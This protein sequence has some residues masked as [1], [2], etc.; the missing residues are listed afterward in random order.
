MHRDSSPPGS[1]LSPDGRQVA[2]LKDE[3][4][5]KA[6]RRRAHVYRI[7]TDG[8]GLVQLT[9]SDGT[10][11]SPRWSPDGKTIAFVAKRGDT[12][13][14]QIYLLPNDGGEARQLSTHA[15]P[16]STIS[17]APDGTAIY[18][19][20]AEDKTAEEKQRDKVKDDVF[21]FDENFK[22]QHLW[23]VTVKDG[24]E[25]RL[26]TGNFDVS[27]YDVSADGAKIV[28]LRAASPLLDDQELCEVWIMEADGTGAMQV[29]HNRVAETNASVSP[30]HSQILFVSDASPQLEPYF[31]GNLFVVPVSGGPPR[32]LMPDFPYDIRSASWSK[33][34]RS[35]YFAANMGVHT[36]LFETDVATGTPRQLTDGK[37]SVGAWRFVPSAGRHVLLINEP[38]RPAEIWTLATTPAA[39]PTRVTHV[40]DYLDRDYRIPRQEAVRWKG[41]DGVTVE[42][43]LFYPLDY[44]EGKRYPLCVQTHGG[45][46]ASDQFQFWGTWG[47]YVQVLTARGWAVLKPNYRGST[48]YGNAFLRDMIGHYFQN[49]H[50][51]VLAGV[52]YLI[53][54]GIAD[55]DRL[56]KMGWSGGSIMTN[57]MIGYTTRFKAAASGA[58]A[59]NWISMLAQ[60]DV[61]LHRKLWFGDK[62]PW[63]KDAPLALYLEQSAI[64]HV[65]SA[66]TPTIF[67]SGER[68]LRDPTPQLVEMFRALTANGVPTHLYIAPREPHGWAELRHQLFKMNAEVEWFEKWAND[69]PYTW[70]R[71]PGDTEV[72]KPSLKMSHR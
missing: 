55:P 32:A 30:D 24:V 53:A 7:N 16:V 9:Q 35:I 18:F 58:G 70:E 45:P 44:Q 13:A 64:S 19:L 22:Q 4:D 71:A 10:E 34:G 49:A 65:A 37:H 1:Q 5:W 2:F 42:G 14:N 3:A 47:D 51:D 17:W 28:L 48:G 60:S 33:D 20:A 12:E 46:A 50:K 26:T 27:D 6:N 29:T 69:R 61:R 54:Q 66:K 63:Q 72:D 38:T 68:D 15:T 41:A 8:T 31:N 21:G 62:S 52:D 39:A 25:S 56:V 57:F 36:E 11:A 40:Y 23:K 59:S 67:W 43:L